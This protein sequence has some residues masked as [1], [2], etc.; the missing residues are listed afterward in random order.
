MLSRHHQV[1]VLDPALERVLVVPT[2]EGPRLPRHPTS[3]PD[4]R[5]LCGTVQVPDAEVAGPPWREDDGLVTHV[6]VAERSG[7][8]GAA[9]HPLAD[10]APLGL[11]P[12]TDAGLRRT[13]RERRAGAPDDGR[14]AGFR[15]GGRA[16]AEAW[17]DAVL[18]RH[19]LGR[20]GPVEPV[21]LWSLSAVL[22][23]PVVRDGQPTHVWFKA[24]CDGF[25]SEPALTQ[26]VCCLAPHLT[27]RVLEVEPER[28]WMLME[29][30]PKADDET[31]PEHAPAIARA[32][33]RLQL[34][35][36][37]ARG[38]L[39]AA[40]LPDRGLEPTLGLLRTVRRESIERPRMPAGLAEAGLEIEPW[41]EER[42]RAVWGAGLPDTLSHGDLHLGNVA[43]VEGAPVFFDWTDACL[44]HPFFD[45]RHLADSARETGGQ[46]AHDAVWEAY[47][48]PWRA[49]FPAVDL[50]ATW[51]LAGDGNAVFQMLSYEQIYRAQPEGSRWELATVVV[52]VLEKLVERARA[53]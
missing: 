1:A 5:E 33:A 37:A 12:A 36:L 43:W 30:I 18:P 38:D 10:L 19:G 29:P 27:P 24:T 48:E 21:R 14:A 2:D 26:A 4:H 3:W 49:A 45:A 41:L 52:E 31:G 34:D 40:G 20:G 7:L 23:F 53:R 44:T 32:L 51:A 6:L 39:R 8:P 35:T 25:R 46:E 9:W 50:D 28:A 13:V 47:A 42:L 17:V 15:P 22:R 16:A 11:T